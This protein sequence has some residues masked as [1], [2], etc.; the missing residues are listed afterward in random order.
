[1]EEIITKAPHKDIEERQ[2]K[3]E[4]EDNKEVKHEGTAD[5]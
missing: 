5:D 1:M 3:E 2:E 4:K